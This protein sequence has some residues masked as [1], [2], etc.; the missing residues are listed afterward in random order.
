MYRILFMLKIKLNLCI[1]FFCNLCNL[2]ICQINIKIFEC[3]LIKIILIMLKKEKEKN[4]FLFVWC[5]GEQKKLFYCLLLWYIGCCF[6]N[7]C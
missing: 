7:I 3:L 2:Y 1:I 5:N 6:Y 4:V